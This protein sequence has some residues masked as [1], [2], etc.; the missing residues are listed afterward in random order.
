MKTFK[1]IN[2][3]FT[4]TTIPTSA[5]NN[6]PNDEYVNIMLHSSEQC[7]E[8]QKNGFTI[9]CR[10]YAGLHHIPYIRV[11]WSDIMKIK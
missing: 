10:D 3:E 9:F 6:T 5:I 2:A 4:V 7:E 8:A 11:R 1:T